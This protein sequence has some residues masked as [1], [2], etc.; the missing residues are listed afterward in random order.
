MFVRTLVVSLL[1]SVLLA[2]SGEAPPTQAP[3]GADPAGADSTATAATTA[4]ASNCQLVMGWDPYEPYQYADNDG[5][6]RGL[7]VELVAEMAKQAGC[8]LSFVQK[9][10]AGLIADLRSGSVSVLAG[11]S[12]VPERESFAIFSQPYRQETFSLY[13]RA[14]EQDRWQGDS[15]AAL[16]GPEH[17]MRIG[18]TDGYIYGNEI[19]QLLDDAALGGQFT[20][21]PFS[22][23]HAANLIDN[24]IDGM[25]EDPFVASAMIRRKGLSDQI[26]RGSLQIKTGDVSLMFSKS[27]VSADTVQAFESALAA[28]RADGR[29]DQIIKRYLP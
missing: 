1:C 16:V 22:E 17:K 4:P 6:V 24:K 3:A 26:I 29:Y 14:G 21:A 25:L 18:I 11:A 27:G 8:N 13:L 2:C 19:D 20:S 23:A 15:L 5:T 28:M 7:D 10:W 9:D 12:K